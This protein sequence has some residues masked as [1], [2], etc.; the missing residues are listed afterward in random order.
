MPVHRRKKIHTIRNATSAPLLHKTSMSKQPRSNPALRASAN[1]GKP[2][3]AATS[4]AGDFE[5]GAVR[6][7]RSR[8]PLTKHPNGRRLGNEARPSAHSRER[9]SAPQVH[10]TEQAATPQLTRNIKSSK[11]S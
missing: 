1:Q 4:R 6:C 7:K 2:P 5:G 3:I 9:S 11:T 8:R 10:G